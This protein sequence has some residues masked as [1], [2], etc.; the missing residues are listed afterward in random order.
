MT[1]RRLW[2]VTGEPAPAA[3]VLEFT[4]EGKFL[5]QI[6]K[7]AQ[8]GGDKP[9]AGQLHRVHN[10]AVDSKG[11]VYTAKVDSGKRARKF[12]FKGVGPTEP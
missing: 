2:P 6:G 8:T 9:Q 7:A 11:N 10:P 4:R 5:L 1:R 12:V 3:P